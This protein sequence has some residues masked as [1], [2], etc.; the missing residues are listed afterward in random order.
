MAIKQEI[1]GTFIDGDNLIKTFSDINHY[2]ERDGVKYEEAIDP[3]KLKRVYTETDEE[4]PALEP[5]E[6]LDGTND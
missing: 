3:A 6:N 5:E 1:A 2:I 4:I